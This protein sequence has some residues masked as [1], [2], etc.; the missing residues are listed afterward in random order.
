M[1]YRVRVSCSDCTGED[2]L[3]C[4]EGGTEV[5]EESF[6]SRAEAQRAGEDYT[7]DCGPWDF[8]VEEEEES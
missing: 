5:L 2:P 1:K 3:G 7:K 4:F 8:E 6:A